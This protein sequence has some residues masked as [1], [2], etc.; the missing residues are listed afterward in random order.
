MKDTGNIQWIA[1]PMG[2]L[3]FEQV[4]LSQSEIDMKGRVGFQAS[5]IVQCRFAVEE[6]N[7]VS[8]THDQC[9]RKEHVIL[10]IHQSGLVGR[11]SLV[12]LRLGVDGNQ[13]HHR[14][15]HSTFLA[16]YEV[17]FQTPRSLRVRLVGNRSSDVNKAF[18]CRIILV[19]TQSL[20]TQKPSH[21]ANGKSAE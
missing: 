7:A 9:F 2:L 20:E 14:L 13:F 4:V 21:Q 15:G 17:A 6:A 8:Q 16:V 18:I 12:G 1:S 11:W 19:F 3:R 5:Y 10:L